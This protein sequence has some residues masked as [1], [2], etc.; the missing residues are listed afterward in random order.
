M[1]ESGATLLSSH[2]CLLYRRLW[3]GLGECFYT[4]SARSNVLIVSPCGYGVKRIIINFVVIVRLRCTIC[5]MGDEEK[6]R[7]LLSEIGRRGGL[8]RAKALTAQ[9]TQG[10]CGLKASKAAAKARTREAKERKARNGGGRP[11]KPSE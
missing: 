5:L 9:A 7:K 1:G 10:E 2:C 6:M 3:L 11:R 8:A 4:R